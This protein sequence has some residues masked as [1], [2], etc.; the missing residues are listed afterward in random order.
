[1]A[2]GLLHCWLRTPQSLVD[3]NLHLGTNWV[4]FVYSPMYVK[5]PARSW[6]I[7]GV[8]KIFI[9]R[10]IPHLTGKL[11]HGEAMQLVQAHTAWKWQREDSTRGLSNAKTLFAFSP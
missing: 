5:R 11:R 4:Y 8:R 1:M 7:L 3:C 9:E 6:H 10:W 2:A